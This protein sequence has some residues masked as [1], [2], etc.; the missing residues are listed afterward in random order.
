M[1]K[2]VLILLCILALVTGILAVSVTAAPTEY[3]CQCCGKAYKD[4]AWQPWTLTD[5]GTNNTLTENGHYYL[6]GDVRAIKSQLRIGD[7]SLTANITIDLRG[8]TMASTKRVF[9]VYPGSTLSIVDSVGGGMVTGKQVD[10]AQVGGVIRINSGATLNLYGGT[11]A[12][13]AT[14]E[15]AAF[16]AAISTEGN[17]CIINIAGGNVTGSAFTPKG[18][19]IYAS[20]GAVINL[21]SG[22]V[23][24]GKANA[25]GAIYLDKAT[26]NITGGKII[27]GEVMRDNA[28]DEAT[29]GN[30]GAIFAIANA[31]VTVKKEKKAAAKKKTTKKAEEKTEE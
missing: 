20:R 9:G 19:A 17:N 13:A 3:T 26:L 7:D 10:N 25:G 1:T 5:G 31:K 4:V 28:A 21:S 23:T 30:G 14:T 8:F 2:K 16:G 6:T 12:D 27:G 22:T 15:H 18:G 11:V 24:G 29:A